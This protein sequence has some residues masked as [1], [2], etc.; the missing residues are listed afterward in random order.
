MMGE[1]VTPVRIEKILEAIGVKFIAALDPFD[2]KK[3]VAAVKKAADS[4]LG[5]FLPPMPDDS[6]VKTETGGVTAVIFRSPCIALAGKA[7][8]ELESWPGNTTTDIDSTRCIG[9]GKCVTETGCPALSMQK[10]KAVIDYSLCFSCSLCS[11]ICPAGAIIHS[12]I[13]GDRS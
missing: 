10:K 4:A 8:A 13:Q 7:A 12:A 2:Q 9:C 5:L 6:P 11:Q 1:T 3:A